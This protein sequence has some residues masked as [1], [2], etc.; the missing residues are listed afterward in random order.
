MEDDC[1]ALRVLSM[2][3]AGTPWQAMLLRAARAIEDASARRWIS[4]EDALP[5]KEG[6]YLTYRPE[7]TPEDRIV[8]LY[9]FATEGTWEGTYFVASGLNCPTLKVTHWMPLPAPPDAG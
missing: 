4:V 6:Y 3:H 9:F 7:H 5:E 1:E 8:A 2:H